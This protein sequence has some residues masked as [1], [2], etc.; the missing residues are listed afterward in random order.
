MFWEDLV[1]MTRAHVL[2]TAVDVITD[3][4]YYWRDRDSAVPSV[5][6][7]RTDLKNLRDRLTAFGLI[8]DF[9]RERG[10]PAL[11]RQHQHKALVNDLW[12]YVR[13]LP[14]TSAEYQR[15]FA[16]LA[17]RYLRQVDQHLIDR[18]P[19]TRKLA[20]YLIASGRQA[21]LVEFAA[22]LAAN[23]GRTPPMVWSL[24][25]LRADLPFRRARTQAKA[26]PAKVFRPQWRELAPQVQVDK[27]S[28]RDRSLLIEGSA[29]VPSMDAGR[30][31]NTTKLVLLVPRRR[32]AL[33]I[34][35]PA[36]SV[37]RP[38]IT[39]ASGQTR[40]SYDW[41]GFRCEISPRWFG[42]GRRWLTGDWN[43]FVL[44]RG[45]AVWRPARLH[46]PGPEAEHPEPM[47]LAPGVS[48]GAHWAGKR[49]QVRLNREP[50]PPAPAAS[51]A[52]SVTPNTSVAIADQRVAVAQAWTSDAKLLLRGTLPQ[53]GTYQVL[54]RHLDGW[55]QHVT[56]IPEAPGQGTFS[57]EVD[58]GAIDVFGDRLPLRDGHWEISLRRTSAAPVDHPLVPA[59]TDGR[60]QRIARKVYRCSAGP[61]HDL[62]LTVRP[63][64]RPAERGRIRRRLLRDL[65]YRVQRLLPVREQILFISFDGK[66]CTDNPLGI[67]RELRRRG[68][69]R[70]QI[71]AVD[72]WSVPVPSAAR[73]VLIGT[74]DYFAAL[75]RSSYLIANDHLTQ[76]YRRRSGQQ[77]IQ[78]WHG[79][80]L[81]RLGYD[82]VSPSSVSG[83]RYLEFLAGDVAQWD[84][85]ISPNPF[86]TPL[87][88]QAFRYEGEISESGY[89]RDDALIADA[90]AG[91]RGQED[92]RAAGIRSRLGLPA[93]KRVAM[94]VPTWRDNQ[95]DSSR[96]YGLD[97]KLDLA[98]ASR[99]LA[100]DYVLLVRGHH[101][102]AGWVLAT[103]TPGFAFDVTGYPDINDLLIVTDVLITDYSSVMF[104]FAPTG[105][106]MLFFTYDLEQYRDQLRGFYFDF[107]ACAPGPLLDTSEQVVAALADLDAVAAKY[108]EAQ[109][110]FRAS[111]CPLDDGKAS[112]RACDRIFKG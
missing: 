95:F 2:A 19:A 107:E 87:M 47:Q 110:A 109:D 27:I 80:P 61:D 55:A 46:S 73:S 59:S 104:D 51:P 9:L 69:E 49:L 30:R 25:R 36:R 38:D 89:P 22:W 39:A 96:R 66:S 101:L 91:A 98:S 68:D 53:P 111:F 88:R 28:W 42:F 93:D 63:A 100:D 14:G 10:T 84:L 60:Q 20:Y 41:S 50:Q 24:G 13:D 34:L 71:W 11:L 44:V 17:A 35:L 106:P 12:L 86:S 23:P 83:S 75:G 90:A 62:R 29:Y 76:P 94:Y 92:G 81:K 5:T 33:P 16:T 56:P 6:Q 103:T 78:T 105:R 77:Y 31:R 102:M 15:E 57:V 67:A 65:Y 72:D 70:A 8:D 21:D 1:A 79:T 82:I 7:S 108:R 85:L 4:I 43:C 48:F 97:F 18:L 58:V 99:A 54:L 37:R 40:Y 52:A 112:A 3:P 32:T 26:V 74:A 45:R 64:L